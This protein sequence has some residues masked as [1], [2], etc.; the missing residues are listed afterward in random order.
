MRSLLLHL[1]TI[2]VAA[3][4]L[5]VLGA[6]CC[7]APVGQLSSTPRSEMLTNWQD[8][9]V[10][11]SPRPIVW[12]NAQA[13]HI[14][15]NTDAQLAAYFC[16]KF[17][18]AT[19]WPAMTSNQATATWPDGTTLTFPAMSPQDTFD[20]MRAP[21]YYA[22]PDCAG[23]APLDVT[24]MRLGT[25]RFETDRGRARMTAWLVTVTGASADMA[26]PAIPLSAFWHGGVNTQG[27]GDKTATVSSDGLLLT[28][29]FTGTQMDGPCG[30]HYNGLVAESSTAIEVAVQR[31]DNQPGT[32]CTVVYQPRSVTVA[33]RSPLGS[34]VVVD[35]IGSVVAVCAELSTGC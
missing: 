15:F 7:S 3:A 5:I 16:H 1:R 29:G 17:Q 31:I 33:L 34:R 32:N 23:R 14:H 30:T 12:L 26:Y 13:L 19:S 9:P 24:A 28:V 10:N 11:Q 18:L 25:A 22:P 2:G 6:C 4:S 21:S 35:S 20:G 27:S 8:F